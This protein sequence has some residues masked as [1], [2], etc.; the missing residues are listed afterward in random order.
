MTATIGQPRDRVDGRQKVTGTARYAAEN[1]LP[2]LVHAVVV[3]AT[4]PS[5][6][7][8]SIDTAAALKASGVLAVIS[9]L[10]AP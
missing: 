6:T 7:I 8:Q 5:G 1:N 9:H 2:D 3:S 10:N 4:I